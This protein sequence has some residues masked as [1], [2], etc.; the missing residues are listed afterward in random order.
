[1]LDA[2][3]IRRFRRSRVLLIGLAVA[4]WTSSQVR[5][6]APGAA[7]QG[8]P[9]GQPPAA[10]PDG[11]AP[12]RY[13]NYF[14]KHYTGCSEDVLYALHKELG[15]RVSKRDLFGLITGQPQGVSLFHLRDGLKKKGWGGEVKEGKAD[16]LKDAK[17]PAIL[18]LKEGHFVLFLGKGES[19]GC[20]VLDPE[21]GLSEVTGTAL[22]ERWGGALLTVQPPADLT[23]RPAAEP[24]I[25]PFETVYDFG[26]VGQ[27]KKII[28]R[29]KF[30]N[31]G[32]AVLTLQP[33]RPSC[34]CTLAPLSKTEYQPNEEGFVEATF[35]PEHKMARQNITV[36]LPS[37][38]PD[39]R[40]IEL[41]LRGVVVADVLVS[42][43]SVYF[44]GVKHRQG[45][46][47][48][49]RIRDNLGKKLS[50]T[51]IEV[52]D[53]NTLEA[54][55]EDAPPPLP[56]TDPANPAAGFPPQPG[57]IPMPPGVTMAPGAEVVVKVKVKPERLPGTMNET[58]R[59]FLDDKPIT[60]SV[61]GEILGNVTLAPNYFYFG[62]V[63][64]GKPASA[65][66]QISSEVP[67]FAIRG[68]ECTLGFVELKTE[69]DGTAPKFK[70]TATLKEGWNAQTV[71]GIVRIITNDDF[72]KTREVHLVGLLKPG[73]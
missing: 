8:I 47:Q 18:F 63:E 67:G 9:P 59:V 15:A 42:P 37:N 64:K 38:D 45:G 51:K 7:P 52:S 19:G 54:L 60:V 73:S 14:D 28:H 57:Q 3:P 1:M 56:G 62:Q 36:T 25:Y 22:E 44:Y 58:V 46:T 48:E 69:Q 6:Q 34:G 23:K 43:P 16:L 11:N 61:V 20:R 24:D 32:T 5:A 39:E 66:I 26:T 71:S 65:T 12:A 13:E 55:W 29:F 35:N 49:V 2:V 70:V 53:P 72:E 40:E 27:D 10:T 68:V 4:A 31:I 41:R 21:K 30:K 33:P 50:V 17:G